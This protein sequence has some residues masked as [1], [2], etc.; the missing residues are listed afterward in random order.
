MK[1]QLPWIASPCILLF[2]FSIFGS[3]SFS[4]TLTGDWNGKRSQLEKDGFKFSLYSNHYYGVNAKGGLSTNNAHRGSISFDMFMQFD[5]EKLRWAEQGKILV[6]TKERY[7]KNINPFVGALSDP[8][9]D[10]DGNRDFY[11]AQLWY[12]QDLV[13]DVLQLRFGYMD[14]QVTL[15]RNLYTASEDKQ[16]MATYF[17]NNNAII[18][19]AIGL[20]ASLF[21]NP[22]E[23]L[24][25][26]LAGAD[27]DA[28]SHSSGFGTTFDNDRDFFGYFQTDIK[29]K[30]KKED[31]YLPGNYRFGVIFDPRNRNQFDSGKA[32]NSDIGFYVSFDQCVMR[33]KANDNQGLGLFFRYGNRHGEVNKIQN[34]WSFG[35][36]YKGL[37]EGRD[38]DI[39]GIGVYEA[40]ASNMFTKYKNPAISSEVGYELFYSFQINPWMTFTPDIQYIHNPSKNTAAR[41]ALIV[42]LRVRITY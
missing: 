34:F 6:H 22:N 13:E 15:D 14:Q 35:A 3:V 30:L 20:S 9:D 21:Y 19:L 29:T 26:V 10:A 5:L 1:R 4:Q 32:D 18:P 2:C 36:H 23:W 28:D 31:D 24:S 41:D 37:V 8:I 39:C 11:V 12:Q 38:K 40:I 17:D 33:E 16:F 7:K 25:F 42:T 27:A